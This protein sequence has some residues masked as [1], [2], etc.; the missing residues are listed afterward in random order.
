[1]ARCVPDSSPGKNDNIRELD[2]STS[3][4]GGRTY[5]HIFC[6]LERVRFQMLINDAWDQNGLCPKVCFTG[7]FDN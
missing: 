3:T 1:M 5:H 4:S 6:F 2:Q 7:L